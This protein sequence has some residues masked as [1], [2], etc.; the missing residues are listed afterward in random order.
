MEEKIDRIFKI[1]ELEKTIWKDIDRY[2]LLSAFIHPGGINLVD[3]PIR[4]Y[5]Q[6]RYGRVDNDVFEFIG[7]AVIHMIDTTILTEIST[8]RLVGITH[9]LRKSLETNILFLCYMQQKNLCQELIKA[10]E[11]LGWK[12]CADIFEAL[13]GV[14]YWHGYYEKGLGFDVLNYI[15]RWLIDVW[16]IGAQLLNLLETGKT[17]CPID[18]GV[19]KWSKWSPCNLIEGT[20][21]RKRQCD[22]P[23]PANGGKF[24]VDPLEEK[25]SCKIV[26]QRGVVK[27]KTNIL[28]F[29]QIADKLEQGDIR[30]FII[31]PKLQQNITPPNI[32]ATFFDNKNVRYDVVVMWDSV[33]NVISPPV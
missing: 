3:K 17:D 4:D 30:R 20:Q 19:G 9:T 32:L 6:E 21:T 33:N 1:L 31:N 5:L 25:R 26:P 29:D 28:T 27:G 2:L 8:G 23:P 16:D 15:K 18:G 10:H 24:C 22:N 12:S 13:I 14:L 11:L 7:D